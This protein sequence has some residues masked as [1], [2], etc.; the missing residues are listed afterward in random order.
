MTL[1]NLMFITTE[2]FFV[3]FTW[4]QVSVSGSCSS[5]FGRIS[6]KRKEPKNATQH[7][8]QKTDLLSWD[9]LLIAIS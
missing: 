1:G 7:A 5:D 6:P 9:Q 2:L 3:N 8:A 4:F